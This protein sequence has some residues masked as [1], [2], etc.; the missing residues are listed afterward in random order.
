M[1][2]KSAGLGF[3]DFHR[4]SANAGNYAGENECRAA[5]KSFNESG[6]VTPATLFGMAFAQGW[7]DPAKSR[8][9]GS[10][11][12]QPAARP[13]PS[14]ARPAKQ[15]A[16]SDPVEVWSR[17]I[18]ATPAEP[19]VYLKRGK[20]DG[21][22]VYPASAPPLV[23]R[24]QNV[25]GYLAAPCWSGDDLQTIQFI[26]PE[27]GGKLNLPG[28]S[29]GDGF[30]V[31]GELTDLVYIVEGLGQAWAAS[32]A[33]GAAAVVCFGAGRMKAVAKTLR[34]KCPAA[35]LVLVP[36]RGKEVQAKTIAA[37][38]N[39]QWVALPADKPGNYDCN[40]YAAEHGSEVLAALLER[41]Q[42]PPMRFKLLTDDD[43]RKLSPL[44]WRIKGVLPETGL[45][46][47]FGAP[48]SGK[49]FLVLDALQ[50]LAA[51]A[52]WFGHRVK[53][54]PVIYCAL[55]GEGGIAGRVNAYRIR[56]GATA[57]NI[58]Y[59][60]QQFSLLSGDDVQDLAKAIRA[61]GGAGVVVLDTLNRA[62]PGSDENSSSD[63]GAIIAAAKNLQTLVGGL[64]L[65]VHHAGKDSSRGLRGHSSLHAALDCA[66]EV[67]RDGDGREWTIAKSKDGSDSVAHAFTLDVVELGTDEGG[68]PVTSC[69]V[70]QVESAADEVRRVLPP[71]SGNLKIAWDAIGEAL[72]KAGDGKPEGAP[73]S[74]PKGRPCLKIEDAIATISSRLAVEPKRKTERARLALTGLAAKGL[75]TLQ[76]GF[77][78]LP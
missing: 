44:Q 21:L 50:S 56:H 2:A 77:T 48:G 74:L 45:A 6:G 16:N 62:A 65:L 26:P 25:T 18:P 53:S 57:E 7:Q 23:I 55:E 20:P 39:G 36:D 34:D 70:R 46:A 63:M 38:I 66:I 5:W 37:A 30:F 14:P 73:G 49:S 1:A 11:T 17:C 15:A 22:R 13:S 27:G 28:A 68:E 9:K 51:S 52:D 54:C 67:R 40:D 64:V 58:R 41:P 43:L 35:Q 47:V 31:V 69:V 72:R 29:F 10:S 60:A 3:D 59:L 19:Y 32:K 4:W 78:W 61:V 42:A 76:E 8:T 75:V 33:T 71:K 24:G 12:S